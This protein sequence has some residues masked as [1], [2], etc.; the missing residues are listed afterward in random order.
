MFP[1]IDNIKG[2]EAVKLVLQNRPSQKPSTECKTERLEIC[3][4]KK[5]FKIW[6]RY[7]PQT[8]GTA[9]GVQN[10]WSCSDLAIY[11]LD[12][13]INKERINSFS[14]LLFL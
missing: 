3:L 2:I 8:N 6:P 11:R 7:L 14:K 1:N 9:T 5:K 13:L 4:Y 12:Q 10:S